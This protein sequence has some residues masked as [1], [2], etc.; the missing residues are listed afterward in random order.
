MGAFEKFL[1]SYRLVQI[2]G[3]WRHP[4][5]DYLKARLGLI[6]CFYAA[7]GALAELLKLVPPQTPFRTVLAGPLQYLPASAFSKRELSDAVNG[8]WHSTPNT[9][10][11]L[12]CGQVVAMFERA[13]GIIE[14]E[15]QSEDIQDPSKYELNT[16]G[17]PNKQ[18][19]L[20][21]ALHDH[22]WVDEGLVL[23]LVYGRQAVIATPAKTIKA[24]LRKLVGDTNATLERLGL[25]R[26]IVRKK[27]RRPGIDSRLGLVHS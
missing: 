14:R 12:P 25:R 13:R 7:L 24:R 15:A 4:T 11:D 3:R 19:K 21:D 2:G 6:D 22:R 17:L 23:L 10:L 8:I 1:D 20:I 26:K 27:S 5:D 18:R 9:V 16:S